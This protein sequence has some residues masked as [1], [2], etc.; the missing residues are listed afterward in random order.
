MRMLVVTF[1]LSIFRS[2]SKI[3]GIAYVPFMSVDLK[4]RFA[5]P[6]PFS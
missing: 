3:N 1:S 4:E 6:V 5:F 2:T